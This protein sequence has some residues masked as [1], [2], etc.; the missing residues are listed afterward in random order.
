MDIKNSP[1]GI[2]AQKTNGLPKLKSNMK[3]TKDG[4]EDQEWMIPV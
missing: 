4:V 1:P 3:I 2:C